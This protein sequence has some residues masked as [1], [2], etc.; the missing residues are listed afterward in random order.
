MSDET[1][2]FTVVV[3]IEKRTDNGYGSEA[4]KFVSRDMNGYEA[5]IMFKD[6]VV[7]MNKP[8]IIPGQLVPMSLQEGKK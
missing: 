8:A 4:S 1:K 3:T 7:F 6:I 2:D 5:R